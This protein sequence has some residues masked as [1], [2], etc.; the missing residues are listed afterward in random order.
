MEGAVLSG[1]LCAECGGSASMTDQLSSHPP[2]AS[3]SRPEVDDSIAASA[4]L[5][6]LPS[7]PVARETAEW[8]K[9]FYLGHVVAAA[10]KDV[11]RFGPFTSGVAEPTSLMDSAEAQSRSVEELA[12]RLGSLGSTNQSTF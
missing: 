6:M 7:R 3:R 8:A 12:E 10:R 11:G 2:L 5:T 9:T 4:P 1:K